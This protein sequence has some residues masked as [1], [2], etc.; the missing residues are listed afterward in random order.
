MHRFNQCK[1]IYD[2]CLRETNE[3]QT[4]ATCGVEWLWP[5]NVTLLYHTCTCTYQIS[6]Q[7]I[8]VDNLACEIILNNGHLCCSSLNTPD[9][10]GVFFLLSVKLSEL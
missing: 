5:P 7:S 4:R 8:P 10:L 9:M 1:S 3:L 6:Y 2:I